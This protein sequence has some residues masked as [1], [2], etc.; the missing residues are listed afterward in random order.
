MPL[1]RVEEVQ[2]SGDGFPQ[3]VLRVPAQALVLASPVM[4]PVPLVYLTEPPQRRVHVVA[5]LQRGEPQH[6][7]YSK[8]MCW[9][10]LDRAIALAGWLKAMHKTA[11]WSRTRDDIRAAIERDGW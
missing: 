11:Q 8:L 10:A 4:V 6:F 5:D 3:L 2:V 1:A 9:V 7:L